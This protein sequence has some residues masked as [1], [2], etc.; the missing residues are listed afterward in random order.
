MASYKFVVLKL[1]NILSLTFFLM[2]Q[3]FYSVAFS[4]EA[5]DSILYKTCPNLNLS[6]SYPYAQQSP[7]KW[8][9]PSSTNPVKGYALLVHG[10][11]NKPEVMDDLG[12][13]MLT[14]GIESFRLALTGHK[15]DPEE[16]RHV[17]TSDWQR[18]VYQGFCLVYE[19]AKK[20]GLPLYLIGYS[21]GGM[22]P[23]E[24]MGEPTG[25]PVV[26]TK[27][28]L[29]APALATHW[30]VQGIRIFVIFGDDY[31]IPARV[32]KEYIVNKGASV[33][34]Y[35]NLDSLL[36]TLKAQKK[37]EGISQKTLI[38]LD[39]DDELISSKGLLAF[40]NSKNLHPAWTLRFIQD[41]DSSFRPL[42][43]HLIIDQR[44]LGPKTWE[45]VKNNIAL[46]LA[47]K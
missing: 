20:S 29:F 27:Q 43:H 34:A 26:F 33:I 18:D 10:L 24:I 12:L 6:K 8:H 17:S 46:F 44:S 39:P 45:S 31:L 25:T 13:Y 32:P 7:A 5:I 9:I 14:L 15:G 40:I 4:K 35:K 2:L 28:I 30:Y 37:S 22:I 36:D 19:K 38:F 42:Y 23:L 3:T 1:C 21:L 47:H 41:R 11:N 16:M